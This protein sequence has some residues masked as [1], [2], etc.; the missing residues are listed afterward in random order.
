MMRIE[1]HGAGKRFGRQWVFKD[2]NY[3]FDAGGQY[4]I[5]GKNGSGKSTFLKMLAG[6]LPPT[7]GHIRCYVDEINVEP[8]R[9]YAHLSVSAP[10]MELIEEF[11]LPELIRFQRQCKA[12]PNN[13]IIDKIIREA[14]LPSGDEKQ[15]RQFS[16]GMKQR[17]K[18]ILAMLS[19]AR[20]LLLDEPC[21]NLDREGREWYGHML[22]GY[23]RNK[24]V[25]VAS[26]HQA[27]EYP[28]NFSLFTLS[29]FY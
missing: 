25:F 21:S 3:V 10:Y 4:A 11:T 18:L 28:G 24:T 14:G 12:L 7:K 8:D 20:L 9:M 6:F 16:S 27:E 26:N 19:D 1:L 17:V 15:I 23:G 13:N 29:K 2:I 5:L 22:A